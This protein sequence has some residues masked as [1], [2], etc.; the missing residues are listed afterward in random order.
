MTCRLI[1]SPISRLSHYRKPSYAAPDSMQIFLRWLREA[2][3]HFSLLGIQSPR[4]GLRGVQARAPIRQ[5]EVVLRAPLR[6]ILTADTVQESEIARRMA[7]SGVQLVNQQSKFAVF[8]L[9]EMRNPDSWWKPYIDILPASF[10]DVP[11][12]FNAN[13]LAWLNGSSSLELIRQTRQCLLEDYTRL[14]NSIR[15]FDSFSYDE[16]QWARVAVATR[17]FAFEIDG[18]QTQGMV[19]F[20]D[21]LN[22]RKPAQVDYAFNNDARCF[23]MRSL[24]ALRAGEAV[25]DSY[26]RKCNSRYFVN[27]GFAMLENQANEAVISIPTPGIHHPYQALLARVAEAADSSTCNFRVSTDIESARRLLS[28]LR[29]LSADGSLSGTPRPVVAHD[30]CISPINRRNETS[31]LDALADACVRT[32]RTFNTS[33]AED[34]ALLQTSH[35][36]TNHRHAVMMRRGEKKVLHHYTRMAQVCS[37]FIQHPKMARGAMVR[38]LPPAAVPFAPYLKRVHAALPD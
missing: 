33:V 14:R 20:A 27:Y 4:G 15:G 17:I 16:F 36:S 37:P 7:D 9:W 31:A 35:L 29:I 23:Q 5:G 1:P 3:A 24:T 13:E 11:L 32:L 10:A 19:P 26:G 28:F 6:C 38:T 8:L 2:G 21:L 34:E 18:R 25:H 30:V 12:F 22:H